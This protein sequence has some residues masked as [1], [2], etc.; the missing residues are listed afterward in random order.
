MGVV[1][2]PGR[3]GPDRGSGGTPR[4]GASERVYAG[5]LRAYPGPFRRRYQEEMVLLFGD[6]LREAQATHGAAGT[7]VTWFRTLLDLASSAIGEHLRKDRTMA[8]SLATFEP[9][10][11]MRVLGL[12]GLIGGVLLLWAFLSSDPFADGRINFIRLLV[13]S[14]AGP[15]IARAFYPRQAALAPRL[16]LVATGAVIIG[17]IWYATWLLLS[18]GVPSKFSGTFGLVNFLAG[19]ALWLSPVLYGAAMRRIGAAW[20]GMTRSR[21]VATRLGATLLLGSSVAWLGDDRLGLVDSEAYG[22]L[23]S[24][25]AQVGVALNGAGWILLGA[26]LVLGSRASRPAA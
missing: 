20:K 4:T 16:A 21:T 23:W 9:T 18:P 5:L 25:I 8:Q 22:Q 15:A 6:Q 13:F 14:L 11:S 12:F 19:L 2:A 26:V 1:Q 10:R 17:G 24:T 3:I 7:T